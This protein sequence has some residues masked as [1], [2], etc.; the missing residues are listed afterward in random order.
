MI[1]K[2]LLATDGSPSAA[3]AAAL[4]AEI[5]MSAIPLTVPQERQTCDDGS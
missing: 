5:R 3:D 4:A 2:T 1:A